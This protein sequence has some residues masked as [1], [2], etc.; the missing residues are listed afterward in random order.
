[1]IHPFI[2]KMVSA[3]GPL[4]YD[5]GESVFG[6]GYANLEKTSGPLPYLGPPHR[7]NHPG[8]VSFVPSALGER[9]SILPSPNTLIKGCFD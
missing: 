9:N 4:F 2:E 6:V 3:K 8:R 7:A 1:M 5:M